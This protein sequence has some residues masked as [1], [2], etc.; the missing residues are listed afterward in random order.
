VDGSG[1][2]KVGWLVNMHQVRALCILDPLRGRGRETKRGE[3]A[4]GKEKPEG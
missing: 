2:E 1:D 3:K 4:G